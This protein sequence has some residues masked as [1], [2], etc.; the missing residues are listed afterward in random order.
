MLCMKKETLTT[1]ECLLFAW[2]TGKA[3]TSQLVP[4][5]FDVADWDYPLRRFR[6]TV[7]PPRA[8]ALVSRTPAIAVSWLASP[9]WGTCSGFWVA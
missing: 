7:S 3:G 2:G 9:V 6:A 5:W 4:A 8:V 1:C